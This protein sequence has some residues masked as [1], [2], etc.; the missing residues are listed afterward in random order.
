MVSILKSTDCEKPN[1]NERL[2]RRVPTVDDIKPL[3]PRIYYST[4]VPRV[5]APKVVQDV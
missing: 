1:K 5:L 4:I 3:G 2:Q